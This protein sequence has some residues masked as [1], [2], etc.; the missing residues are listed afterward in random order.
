MRS[1]IDAVA[2]GPVSA[3]AHQRVSPTA[4]GRRPSESTRRWLATS[5]SLQGGV[6]MVR[7]HL[8]GRKESYMGQESLPGAACDSRNT[9]VLGPCS[10]VGNLL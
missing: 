5:C 7:D 2:P 6:P 9:I 3:S 10:R 1:A 8:L 4:P